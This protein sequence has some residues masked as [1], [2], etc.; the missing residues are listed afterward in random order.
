MIELNARESSAKSTSRSLSSQKHSANADTRRTERTYVRGLGELVSIYVKPA[1]QPVK[2]GSS[3]TIIPAAERKIVF[4]GVESILT[5]HRDNLLNALENAVKPL[6]ES[7]DDEEGK[8]STATAHAVGE[9]FRTYIAYMKQYSSYINNFDN[10]LSRMKTWT[11]IA[12]PIAPGLSSRSTSNIGAAAASVGMMSAHSL[13][14]GDSA[15][16]A[17][18]TMNTSQ[19]KRVKAFLKRCR[20]HPKHSQIN[21]DSYLLLPIQRVPRYKLLLEDL[22]MCTPPRTDETRDTLDDALNEIAGLASMM[23]EEKR[24]AESRLRLYQWQ[25]R[26]TS[27]GPS[28]LV[29]PHRKLILDGALHLIR[30]VKKAA[31]YVEVDN[32]VIL[33]GDHTIMPSKTV[34]PVEYINPE[35]MNKQMMLILCTD[36]MVLVSKAH[37]ADD[38]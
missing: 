13:P 36:M 20:E 15:S 4:G 6:L 38:W 21:L 22:A 3:E 25:Q 29:Q 28:P 12:G 32:T 30:L 37:Q 18:G 10:A 16:Q 1:A 33:D 27:R 11:S 34:V 7:T 14:L 17:G 5:I 24:D 8:L 26:I 19:K 9:V 2:P 35:P 23:N 31:S